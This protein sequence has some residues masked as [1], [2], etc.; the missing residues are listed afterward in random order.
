MSLRL[1]ENFWNGGLSKRSFSTGHKRAA[2]IFSALL[3]VIRFSV[4][5]ATKGPSWLVRILL[6]L[7]EMGTKRGF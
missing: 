2:Y 3:T 1:H 5:A 7:V 6:D 4:S